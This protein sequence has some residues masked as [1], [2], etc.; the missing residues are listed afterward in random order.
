ME[1]RTEAESDALAAARGR[2]ETARL[3]INVMIY[4][5]FRIVFWCCD[6]GL[7][8]V[9]ELKIDVLRFGIVHP[10]GLSNDRILAP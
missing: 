1:G 8:A 7:L 3:M 2:V 4:Y 6:D 5:D 9:G 10:A